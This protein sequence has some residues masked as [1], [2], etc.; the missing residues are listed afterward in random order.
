MQKSWSK[1]ESGSREEA[2]A[3]FSLG[4]YVTKHVIRTKT[5]PRLEDIACENPCSI[6]EACECVESLEL[7]SHKSIVL[8]VSK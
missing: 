7:S 1:A 3:P 8:L 4:C 2:G 6:V 5:S